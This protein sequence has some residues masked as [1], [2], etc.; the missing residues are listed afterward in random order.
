MYR[1]IGCINKI[2][3][4][5][6]SGY[7]IHE[8]SQTQESMRKRETWYLFSW[9]AYSTG[10]NLP[11]LILHQAVGPFYF[12]ERTWNS[13]LSLFVMFMHQYLF[14]KCF[15]LLGKSKQMTRRKQIMYKF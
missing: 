1:K 11:Y 12:A 5:E 7:I 8:F 9:A 10:R 3:D 13:I 2:S 4:H 14:D 15:T 6:T